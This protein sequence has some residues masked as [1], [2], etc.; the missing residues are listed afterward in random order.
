VDDG[1]V[2]TFHTENAN[3]EKTAVAGWADEQ[4]NVVD[5]E[6]PNGVS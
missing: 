1:R 5:V 6:L 4:R 2:V 3:F